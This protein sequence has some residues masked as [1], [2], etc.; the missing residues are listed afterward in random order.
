MTQTFGQFMDA[1]QVD[2]KSTLDATQQSLI[3]GLNECVDY[4]ERELQQE[5]RSV[6]EWW[7]NITWRANA[8]NLQA[9]PWRDVKQ[10]VD[11]LN[12]IGQ[13]P[14][15]AMDYYRAEIIDNMRRD[16]DR[17]NYSLQQTKCNILMDLD[18]RCQE[19]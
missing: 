15:F 11:A 14:S 17:L 12:E 5:Q 13:D 10:V 4:R 18:I 8:L 1:F 9:D 2:P 19:W 16:A 3:D 6:E 7:E